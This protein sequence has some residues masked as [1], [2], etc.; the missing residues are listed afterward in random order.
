MLRKKNILKKK[1][2]Q[3]ILSMNY[4][5]FEPE[6]EF[7]QQVREALYIKLGKILLHRFPSIEY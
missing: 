5:Q 3:L 2:K 7:S 6:M 1:Y 4:V